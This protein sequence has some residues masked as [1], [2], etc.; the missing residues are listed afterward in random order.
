[1]ATPS[2]ERDKYD[3]AADD[4]ISVAEWT[5]TGNAARLAQAHAGT[6]LRVS[7]MKRWH[8][9]DR[10]RWDIDHDTREVRE[11][12]KIEAL[13]LPEGSKEA[14]KFKK[15]SLSRAGINAAVA[16]AESMP[17]IR[18]KANDLDAYPELLNTPS[19]IVNLRTGELLPHDPKFKLTRITRYGVAMGAPT[20]KFDAFMAETFDN[21]QEM[22][23]FIQRLCGLMLLGKV[24]EHILPFWFGSGANGKG[25]LALICQG[26]LG[27]AD[28]GGYAVS[29]PTGF[30]LAG[31]ENA[32]TTE[33]ARMRGARL[34]VCSEQTSGRKFDEAKV[35][36]F[37]GGDKLTGRFMN[38]DFFDFDPSHLLLVLSNYLPEVKEGGESFWRRTRVI[39]F[40]HEVPLHKRVDE[41]DRKILEAD[42]PGIHGW[43]VNGAVQV[44]KNGL[45]CPDKVMASTREYQESEDALTAF[46]EQR[47]FQNPHMFAV[48]GRFRQAYLQFCKESGAEPLNATTLTLKLQREHKVTKGKKRINGKDTRVYFGIEL[49]DAPDA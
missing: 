28:S 7:D 39:E 43:M 38:G 16:V 15:H 3:D 41:L 17:D 35:K 14:D 25:C 44:L 12:A 30:L 10:T 27:D 47:C 49:E 4:L 24:T 9:W 36:L 2:R 31:R 11:A 21:D 19:S 32:Y 1:M 8:H 40:E 18:C 6:L 23:G 20:P 45:R 42:G 34:V 13:K 29:A 33:I 48:T 22:I 37:T 5:D 46:I 26:I